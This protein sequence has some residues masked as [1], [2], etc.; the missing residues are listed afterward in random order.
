[1]TGYP[2]VNW[3][4]ERPSVFMFVENLCDADSLIGWPDIP[5]FLWTG[6]YF[7]FVLSILCYSQKRFICPIFREHFFTVKSL[8]RICTVFIDTNIY[9]DTY[10]DIRVIVSQINWRLV[11]SK[12]WLVGQ[13]MCSDGKILKAATLSKLDCLNREKWRKTFICMATVL[14]VKV[15]CLCH[16]FS[17]IRA[18]KLRQTG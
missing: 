13:S 17:P 18:E 11:I 16:S 2:N 12:S 9:A 5:Q 4:I 7:S 6:A 14:T 8:C 3:N 10:W 1:M 15:G